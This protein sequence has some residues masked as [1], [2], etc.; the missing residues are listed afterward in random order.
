[1]KKI[2]VIAI[3][4]LVSVGLVWA[5][6][7]APA[8]SAQVERGRYLVENVAMCGECHSPRDSGGQLDHSRWLDGAPTWFS[9]VVPQP[10]W[11]FRAPA[12]A[13]LPSFNDADMTMV[14]EKGLQPTGRPIRPPMHV[15]H[16][17]HEDATAIVAYLRSLPQAKY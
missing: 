3:A 13:G 4:A 2:F 7:K 9:A 15:Y 16:M 14:L 1:M 10:D 11:A 12:L 17:S 8:G 6:Q 5:A